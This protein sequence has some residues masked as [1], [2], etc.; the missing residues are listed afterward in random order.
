MREGGCLG[1]TR[2]HLEVTG[3]LSPEL[4]AMDAAGSTLERGHGK[5]KGPVVA[6]LKARK[7]AV[8]QS[9]GERDARNNQGHEAG[10]DEISLFSFM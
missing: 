2:F 8:T 6:H 5:C 7:K 1:R 4:S 9:E 3:E 10:R